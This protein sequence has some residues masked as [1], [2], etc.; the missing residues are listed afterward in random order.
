[1]TYLD[2][3]RLR[4]VDAAEFRHRAPY[5]WL[6][7]RG[8]LTDEGHARLVATLPDVSLFD[9]IFGEARSH[10]QKP[11]DRF[12]LDYRHDLP[13]AQEW[14]DFVAELRGDA[15]QGFL[16]RM[17]GVRDIDIGFHWH[18]TPNGCSVSPHCDARRK[19]GS[20]IFYLNT[21]EDWRPDWGGETL[22]LD[23]GG[24]LP[25]DSAPGFDAFDRVIESDA[26]GN[27]SL[28]FMRKG[29]SWHGV[30]EIRAPEGKFR[31]V[32]IVVANRN[33]PMWRLRRSLTGKASRY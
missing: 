12:S 24:R 14:K 9:R 25:T 6:N 15:Y 29:H 30:R 32:F 28:L 3:D 10:G 16:R 33:G 7:E 27:A 20:H 13:I 23:D 31:K 18:Y 26:M 8:L 21:D 2:F 11:H 4:A 19:L 1:M 5:P 22:I 17:Y